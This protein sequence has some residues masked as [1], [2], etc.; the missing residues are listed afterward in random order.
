MP[1]MTDE[2]PLGPFTLTP[3]RITLLI[4]GVLAI[5]MITGALL[6]GVANYAELGQ[7]AAS[8]SQQPAAPSSAS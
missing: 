1:G 4:L 2:K 8:S 5:V 7:S 6:G 3:A